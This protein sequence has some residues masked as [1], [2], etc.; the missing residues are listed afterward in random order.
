MSVI[1][2]KIDTINYKKS[3]KNTLYNDCKLYD[4]V[5]KLIEIENFFTSQLWESMKKADI[6]KAH[7]F[8]NDYLTYLVGS[9]KFAI[10]DNGVPIYDA[11]SILST[12]NDNHRA[13]H[14]YIENN[15]IPGIHHVDG[16]IFMHIGSVLSLANDSAAAAPKHTNPPQSEQPPKPNH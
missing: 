7:S 8:A 2:N 16:I 9:D 12:F 10:S 14:D 15:D 5:N 4:E 13:T 3:V 6:N 11:A 1:I